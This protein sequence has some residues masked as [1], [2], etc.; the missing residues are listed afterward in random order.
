MA[1]AHLRRAREGPW[2]TAGKARSRAKLLWRSLGGRARRRA[3]ARRPHAAGLA[4]RARPTGSRGCCRN[5]R[6]PK[7]RPAGC[8]PGCRSPTASASSAIS[9]PQREPAWWA[10]LAAALAGICDRLSSR[11]GGRSAFRWRWRLRRSP[12][13]SPPPRCKT[14]AH[15][16]SGAGLSDLERAG[17]RLR[18]DARG[19]RAQR[20]HRGARRAHR[21]APH[22]TSSPSACASR[23]AKAPR[24][25]S[26]ASSPS[27][28]ICRRRCSR[29][30]PAATISRATCISS[31]S[32]PP[33]TCS[34]RSR[35]QTPP[36]RA[37][38]TGCAPRRRSTPCARRS[39]TASTRV[40]PGDRGSIASALITGKRNAI[41]APVSNAFYI[42]SLA[43]VLAISG[44]H[45]AVVAGIAFFFIRALA[46]AYPVARRAPADQEMGGRRRARHRRLLSGAVGRQRL[47]PARLHHDRHRADRRHGRPAG[48]DLPHASRS[49]LSACC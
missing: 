30:A 4:E 5:G 41:S 34:A 39:T 26:P 16:A 2:Q 35:A 8:C 45:M 37:G 25:R 28:R 13:A 33:A 23:C 1:L 11:A 10:A 32:A 7:S 31:R 21:R 12:P 9:P 40:L 20:P 6:W 29:C 22:A 3:P 46:R 44:F 15:R 43:H 27:R 24:P 14:A 38:P 42:S 36:Q 47:H 49:R 19:A 17:H 18:R 48:A